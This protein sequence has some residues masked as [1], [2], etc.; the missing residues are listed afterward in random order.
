MDALAVRI[1]RD[2]LRAAALGSALTPGWRREGIAQPGY[3][4]CRE[5]A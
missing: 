4:R 2:Q 3:F 1:S 5:A